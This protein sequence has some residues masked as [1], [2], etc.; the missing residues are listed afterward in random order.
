METATVGL[1][2]CWMQIV[3]GKNPISF[4]VDELVLGETATLV[5][6][7]HERSKWSILTKLHSETLAVKLEL[8]LTKIVSSLKYG[9][10]N[11]KAL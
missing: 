10:T 11:C 1:P 9:M 4:G 8:I 2:S 3:K 7:L 5:V 6:F